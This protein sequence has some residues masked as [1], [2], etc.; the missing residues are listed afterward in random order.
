MPY[1]PHNPKKL[2]QKHGSN[3]PG[4][5]SVSSPRVRKAVVP[6]LPAICNDQLIE[7]SRTVV[8]RDFVPLLLSQLHAILSQTPENYMFDKDMRNSVLKAG[9]LVSKMSGMT[10]KITLNVPNMEDLTSLTVEEL[11]AKAIEAQ[12]SLEEEDTDTEWEF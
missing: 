9:D 5:P 4:A 12:S 10:Q 7:N 1:R 11:T 3:K 6:V 8:L 2:T